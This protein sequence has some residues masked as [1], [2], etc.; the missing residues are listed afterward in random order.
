M[1]Q[2]LCPSSATWSDG[3]ERLR[4]GRA[5][6]SSACCDTQLPMQ[7]W[8]KADKPLPHRTVVQTEQS[9]QPSPAQWCQPHPLSSQCWDSWEMCWSQGEHRHGCQVMNCAT[10]LVSP[11]RGSTNVPVAQGAILVGTARSGRGSSSCSSLSPISLFS[12][13]LLPPAMPDTHSL[14]PAQC[15]RGAVRGWAP[16]Y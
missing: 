12:S 4:G 1:I 10:P 14:Q 5:G 16:P 11:G 2:C 6:G 7:P 13:F 3:S 9:K 8:E 15:G